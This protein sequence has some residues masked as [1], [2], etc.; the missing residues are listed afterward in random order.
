MHSKRW[1]CGLLLV[2][3]LAACGT[4]ATPTS[5]PAAAT[6]AAPTPASD[7]NTSDS[8]DRSKL[9]EELHVFA[10]GEYIPE[11]VVAAFEHEYNV[12]VTVDTY[13]SNEEMAAKV[14]AGSSGYDIVQPSDYMVALLAEGGYLAEINPANIPNLHNIDPANMG[15]YYDPDNKYS[16][17][18]LWGTTGIAFDTTAVEPA[19]DSWAILF[20]PAKLE[21]YKNRTSMLND[22]REVIGAA[23]RYLGKDQNSADAAD[24]AAAKALL[25]AQKPLLAKYNSDNVYQDLASGEIIL[26]QAWSGDTGLAMIDNPNIGWV[27][28]KEGGVIWQDNLAILKETPNQYTAETFINFLLRPEIGAQIAEFTGYLTP[29]TAAAPLVSDQLKQIYQII[30]PDAAT[31]QRLDWLRK[32]AN[33][34]AFSDVWAQVKSN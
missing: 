22:E 3:V 26:A 28:P 29:N 8:V 19:P 1:M 10:W 32:G 15:L 12:K 17:P 6:S 13:S 14:R 27:I 5:T 9:A 11:E 18:Y 31:R 20:D 33:A 2:F 4:N 23:L 16:V 21:P 24:L 30:Q 7:T 25:T 34:T